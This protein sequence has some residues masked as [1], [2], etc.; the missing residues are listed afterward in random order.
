MLDP[1]ERVAGD[2]QPQHLTFERELVLRL[3]LLVGH[4]D[5]EHLGHGVVGSTPRVAEEVELSD[6]LGLLGSDDRFDGLPVY[7]EQA[8]PRMSE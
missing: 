5:R 4:L 7:E 8:L 3:P 6:R 2:V 1:I